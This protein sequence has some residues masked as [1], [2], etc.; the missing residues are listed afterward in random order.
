MD[1][2]AVRGEDSQLKVSPDGEIAIAP[3]ELRLITF[4][5]D[6]V[7][8]ER[9]TTLLDRVTEVRHL[10]DTATMIRKNHTMKC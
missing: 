2:P 3:R 10:F 4:G 6:G 8:M 7:G 9:L 1:P 5:V